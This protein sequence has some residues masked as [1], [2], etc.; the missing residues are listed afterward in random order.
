MQEPSNISYIMDFPRRRHAGRMSLQPALSGW[1]PAAT[2]HGQMGRDYRSA[3]V[4]LDALRRGRSVIIP[5][6]RFKRAR[7]RR[8]ARP[9]DTGEHA[10]TSVVPDKGAVFCDVGAVRT[11]SG[12]AGPLNELPDPC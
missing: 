1:G 3:V 9:A 12:E 8:R 6:S 10:S 5:Y 2:V 7:A 4:E 11:D